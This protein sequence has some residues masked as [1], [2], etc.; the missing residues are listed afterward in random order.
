MK[1]STVKGT[2]DYLPK[3]ARLR[4]FMQRQILETYRS[5]GFSQILTPALEDMGN[6]NQSEG[7]D[8]LRLMFQILKRGEKL[9]AAL[10]KGQYDALSDIGL[11]Y[12]LTLPL[13]RYY[14]NNKAH[15]V[16]P[17]KC[18]Q[19]GNAYRAEN[20][21]KGRYREF[22]QCDIDILGLASHW[23][24]VELIATTAAALT[25]LDIGEFRVRINDRQ[26][27]TQ[28][29]LAF[30]FS[31]PQIPALCILFDKMDKIGVS[32]IEKELRQEIAEKSFD[33]APCTRFLEYLK[34]GDFSMEAC[35]RIIG[36][37]EAAESLETIIRT[38]NEISQ[39]Q[40]RCSFDISLVRGQGYYTGAVFE[41]ESLAYSGSLAGGGRYDKLI[42]KFTKENVPAV[43]FSIGFERIYDL[44][45]NRET[46]IPDGKEK[47]ALFFEA[48]YAA[49]FRAA[50]VLRKDYDVS[51][52]Q[53][54]KKL[55]KF[56]DRLRLDNYIGFCHSPGAGEEPGHSSSPEA[57]RPQFFKN[58]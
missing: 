54:P 58:S 30:G 51:I 3:E 35:T 50:A 57:L 27:L 7:G 45:L 15:L 1:I 10:A 5:A 9:H 44:L 36:E 34:E 18:I 53:K 11:R 43:G 33:P 29:F 4:D 48:D 14:A 41:V 21:Q 49:A 8:N 28:L 19:I 42:G 6:L 40:Y 12:D 32:G 38:V 46:L 2:R 13:S 24:E 26:I 20:P 47:L 39:G 52:F 56:L 23:A 22:M 16:F 31:A 55:G 17:M 37:S 25:K